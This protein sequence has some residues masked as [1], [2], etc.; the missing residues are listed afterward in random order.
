MKPRMHSSLLLLIT[1]IIG[2][3]LGALIQSNLRSGRMKH[4]SIMHSE[5]KFV[6]SIE[7]AIV[8]TD[9]NQGERIR[10]VLSDAAP[11]V[12][13]KFREC[14][15]QVRAE[16]DAME[17]ELLPLLDEQQQERLRDRLKPPSRKRSK[18]D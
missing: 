4:N 1:L 5:E 16:I 17:V 10:A 2:I 18:K 8:P 3:I 11:K 13:G 7:A 14:R 9:E 15:S 12:I 6:E